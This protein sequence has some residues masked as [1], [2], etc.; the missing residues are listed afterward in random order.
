[1]KSEKGK[2]IKR[3]EN[4]GGWRGGEGED[5][6]VRTVHASLT[7]RRPPSLLVVVVGR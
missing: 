1:M 2:E 4:F 7:P 6:W 5:G 3:E